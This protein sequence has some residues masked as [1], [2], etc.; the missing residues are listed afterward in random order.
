VRTQSKSSDSSSRVITFRLL[1]VRQRVQ[2]YVNDLCSA[3]LCTAAKNN[4]INCFIRNI[5]LNTLIFI[6]ASA[7]GRIGFC[8]S[9]IHFIYFRQHGLQKNNSTQTKTDRKTETHSKNTKKLNYNSYSY[10]YVKLVI[11]YLFNSGNLAH[12]HTVVTGKQKR[13]I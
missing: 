9:F 3:D 13:K 12:A 1:G 5:V 6:D 11:Y 7:I 2:K 10:E 8:N 4:V